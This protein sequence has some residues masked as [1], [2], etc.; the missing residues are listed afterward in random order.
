MLFKRCSCSE[1]TKCRHPYWYQIEV[2]GRRYRKTTKTA[3]R[4][5]AERIED[6]RRLDL[7]EHG[8]GI[9]PR[10][11]VRL[12]TLIED[13]CAHTSTANKTSYKDRPV[14]DRLLALVG[15][16][17]VSTV[18]AFDLER[19][20]TKRTLDVSRSTVNRELNIIR[21]CFSRAVE[22][23]FLDGSPAAAVKHFQVD[24]HRVRVLADDELR[25]LLGIT[26]PFVRDLC[27]TTLESLARLS[28]LLHLHKSHI[29]P[30]WIETIDKGG[31]LL[32]RTVTPETRARLLARAHS[33]TGM[34]FGEP[35][36]GRPPSQ[37]TASNRILRALHAAGI[38]DASHHTMRHTG[39]TIML[40]QGVNP[41]VIQKLAGWSS[42]RMLER[43]GHARDAETLRAVRSVA[44]HLGVVTKTHTEDEKSASENPGN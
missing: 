8:A 35:E 6:K 13:Y 36:G 32:R 29:G 5:L 24:D 38:P 21:G 15:D 1:Q 43:Y 40:E 22:W 18:T 12:S 34:V 19:W 16:R 44:T 27:L 28:A 30:S 2:H 4:R 11:D 37:Q 26:D 42:L 25:T 7:L 33:V 10:K 41:R 9:A 17:P 23:R 31:V 39:V 3:T 14:L 20:K